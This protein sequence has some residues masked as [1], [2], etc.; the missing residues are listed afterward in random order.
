MLLRPALRLLPPALIC[1]VAALI[2]VGSRAQAADAVPAWCHDGGAWLAYAEDLPG[3]ADRETFTQCLQ[4]GVQRGTIT[5]FDAQ[6]VDDGVLFDLGRG[7]VFWTL[8]GLFAL[9]FSITAYEQYV[10][11]GDN[12][13][14]RF[15]VR[16]GLPR[17]TEPGYPCD[18]QERVRADARS[19]SDADFT[20]YIID[21]QFIVDAPDGWYHIVRD[22]TGFGGDL[23]RRGQ[24]QLKGVNGAV[25]VTTETEQFRWQLFDYHGPVANTA[26][27]RQQFLEYDWEQRVEVELISPAFDRTAQ[28]LLP[29]WPAY[30]REVRLW[31]AAMTDDLLGVGAEPIQLEV[32][33][34]IGWQA[35]ASGR[36]I[37]TSYASTNTML[38]ELAHIVAGELSG[39]DGRFAATLLAIWERYI[40]DF[41]GAR[42]RALAERYGVEIGEPAHLQPISDRTE[43]V[44]N[45]LAKT[46]PLSLSDEQP[47]PPDQLHYSITLEVG[48]TYDGFSPPTILASSSQAPSCEVQQQEPDGT[49]YMATYGPEA[50]FTINP[51]GTWNGLK[52]GLY[53]DD[54]ETGAYVTGTPVAP[55]RVRVEIS[56]L[57][58]D[59]NPQDP[60]RVGYSEIIVVAPDTGR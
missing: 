49:T 1:A 14:R 26:H 29:D 58:P 18:G 23:Q 41:D 44:R 35:Y 51:G 24:I 52:I 12:C 40:P 8:P 34:V 57:C 31:L 6:L 56:T 20:I 25:W 15:E 4:S 13:D 3:S 48:R 16:D 47:I 27:D 28:Y 59:G 60:L 50:E 11:I 32:L 2:L 45:L 54:E 39:H 42:A 38:H 7:S 46:A 17:M 37:Y 30:W 43:A 33:D 53:G 55:G 9:E 36:T 19:V 21:T 22:Q 10:M 5:A